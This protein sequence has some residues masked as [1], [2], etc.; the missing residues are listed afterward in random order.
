MSIHIGAIVDGSYG[1]FEDGLLSPSCTSSSNHQN[2]CH[3]IERGVVLC[4]FSPGNWVVHW[5]SI[6]HAAH[7]PFN[8]L[9]VVRGATQQSVQEVRQLQENYIGGTVE[10]TSYFDHYLKNTS[11]TTTTAIATITTTNSTS[12]TTPVTPSPGN[13][14]RGNSCIR[15]P[16][17]LPTNPTKK[18]RTLSSNQGK[19]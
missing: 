18:T 4:S 3:A 9:R 5:F 19:R 16:P 7:V 15:T 13:K 6:Q 8:K 17:T 11:T 12:A 1:Q 2:P 14:K 10:L